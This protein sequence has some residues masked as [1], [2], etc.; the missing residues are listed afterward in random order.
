M[1]IIQGLVTRQLDT[2]P[3]GFSPGELD[4]ET[5]KGA[6]SRCGNRG[7]GCASV[8]LSSFFLL[9][10][11]KPGALLFNQLSG[12]GEADCHGRPITRAH[13][14][15]QRYPWWCVPLFQWPSEGTEELIQRFQGPS[16]GARFPLVRLPCLLPRVRFQERWDRLSGRGFESVP[17]HPLQV[18]RV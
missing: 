1:Q 9:V 15:A 5:V 8:Q 16:Q 6:S 10:F 4:L 7:A 14:Q 18:G 17:G 13:L 3:D 2:P 12:R 11:V